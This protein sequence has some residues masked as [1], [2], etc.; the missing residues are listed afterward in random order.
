MSIVG[1]AIVLFVATNVDD[2][3]VLMVLFADPTLRVG[4]IALGQSI[5]IMALLLVSV[6][7][8]V[9]SLVAAP[10]RVGLLGLLPLLI[11]L[12]KLVDLGRNRPVEA[13]TRPT[14]GTRAVLAVAAVTV[15]NGGDNIAVYT[16]V[17]GNRSAPEVLVV[18]AVF[19]CLT[20][21]W[22][23]LAHRLV[24]H[25]RLAV[26]I[27]RHGRWLVPLVLIGLGLLT[28]HQ[29]GSLALLKAWMLPRLGVP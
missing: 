1:L 16:P 2:L 23:W 25:P 6:A 13:M 28:L 11:G 26:P 29:A 5:G 10:E 8:S 21:L 14:A 17:L 12:K 9:V 15:A 22:L 4:Q 7:A 27:R 18:G 3:L 20:A 19:C 24:R